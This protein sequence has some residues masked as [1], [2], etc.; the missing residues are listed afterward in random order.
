[1]K[2]EVTKVPDGFRLN[3]ILEKRGWPSLPALINIPNR[4]LSWDEEI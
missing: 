4:L 3:T 1:M 2:I